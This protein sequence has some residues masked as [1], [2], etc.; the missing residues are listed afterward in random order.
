ML[1]PTPCWSEDDE[2]F[3]IRANDY[4]V[5]FS[6]IGKQEFVIYTK[7][8]IFVGFVF[9]DNILYVIG[10]LTHNEF[11]DCLSVLWKEID[12]YYGQMDVCMPILG[13][14]VTRMGDESL[15]QQKLLDIIIESYKLSAHKLKP[16]CQLHI[17]CKK[18]DDFSLNKIGETI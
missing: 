7:E 4:I 6:N 18:R 2:H 17:I 13:S 5:I 9:V 16:P 8:Y 14:G 15:T 11:L 3:A 10:E 1:V 12:K